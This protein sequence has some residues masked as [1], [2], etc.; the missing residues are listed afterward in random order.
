MNSSTGSGKGPQAG[1]FVE[2]LRS[3]RTGDLTPCVKGASGRKGLA[4]T[5]VSGVGL[6]GEPG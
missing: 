5:Y 4:D 6:E 2:S 3:K 1:G